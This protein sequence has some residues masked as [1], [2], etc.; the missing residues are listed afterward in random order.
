MRRRW[1]TGQGERDR[2]RDV[3]SDVR[4]R[5]P[6]CNLRR[7]VVACDAVGGGRTTRKW[8]GATAEREEIVSDVGSDI[9]IETRAKFDFDIQTFHFAIFNYL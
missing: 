9:N 7:T 3:E 6:I 4:E 2:R 1:K 5:D 8:G